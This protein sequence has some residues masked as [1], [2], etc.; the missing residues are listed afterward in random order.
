MMKFF[1]T[2]NTI[3]RP[4]RRIIYKVTN[5]ISMFIILLIGFVLGVLVTRTNVIEM[6]PNLSELLKWVR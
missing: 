3:L 4:Y 6:I 2:L 1:Y 5:F